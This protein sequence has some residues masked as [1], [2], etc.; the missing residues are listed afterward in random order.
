M[1]NDVNSFAWILN[2]D[3]RTPEDFFLPSNKKI[4]TIEARTNGSLAGGIRASFSNNVVTDETW[5]CAED[6]G[7]GGPRSATTATFYENEN[8]Q[9]NDFSGDAA[10]AQWIWA[11]NTSATSVWRVKTF[12]KSRGTSWYK[13]LL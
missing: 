8:M 13:I 10:K 4:V 1:T 9:G 7:K 3:W 2:C 5:L 12:S 11:E 6:G